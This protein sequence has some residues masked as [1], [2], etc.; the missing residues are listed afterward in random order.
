MIKEFRNKMKWSQRDMARMIGVS[1]VTL[2]CYETTIRL[3][4][5]KTAYRIVDLAQLHGITLSLED[6]Y[7]RHL[8]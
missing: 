5:L 2:C 7:P 8:A 3:P 4:R 1:P 6:I